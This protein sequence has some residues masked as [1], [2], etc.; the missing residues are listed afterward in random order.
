MKKLKKLLKAD[1]HLHTKE[2]PQDK[3]NYSAKELINYM[4]KLNFDVI[5]ITNHN[6][7]T[8][9]EELADY[10]R[11]KNIL[12]IPGVE[13]TIQEKHILFYNVSQEEI[14]DIKELD[15]IKK[16]K[17]KK[18]LI[19]AAHP[20]FIINSL[21]PKLLKYISL[22]DAVEYSHF[23][24]KMINF[25]RKAVKISKKF[26]KP[27]LGTSDSHFLF[28]TGYTYSLINSEKK[29]NSVLKAIKENK[30]SIRTKPLPIHKFFFMVIFIIK[31][32]IRKFYK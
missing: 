16:I 26:N 25:N 32:K 14:N 9:S 12:L 13:K 18:N 30:V 24:I 6:K 21:G 17:H 22:F 29:I 5:S 3:I 7:I 20:F 1:L 10:A 4:S 23:Y 28:Q 31:D 19:V 2:D 27:L 15:D 8:Y 11:K